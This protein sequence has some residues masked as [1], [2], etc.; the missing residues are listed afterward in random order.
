MVLELL[1]D[2]EFTRHEP[3]ELVRLFAFADQYFTLL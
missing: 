2:D 1:Y 3:E